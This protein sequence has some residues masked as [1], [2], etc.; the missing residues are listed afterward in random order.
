MQIISLSAAPLLVEQRKKKFEAQSEVLNFKAF[1]VET[2]RGID[3]DAAWIV[4]KFADIVAVFA[5]TA[6]QNNGLAKGKCQ[7]VAARYLALGM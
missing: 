1:V 2:L 4:K 3:K 5:A 7:T 6:N